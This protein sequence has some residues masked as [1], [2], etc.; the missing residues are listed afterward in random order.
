MFNSLKKTTIVTA[1]FLGLFLLQASFADHASAQVAGWKKAVRKSDGR[2]EVS[3]QVLVGGINTTFGP[4][5]IFPGQ[6]TTFGR[7]TGGYTIIERVSANSAGNVAT[8]RTTASYWWLGRRYTL[9]GT[10]LVFVP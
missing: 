1:S 2:I 9:S 8:F 5:N 3:S 4:R 6:T 7:T 10:R